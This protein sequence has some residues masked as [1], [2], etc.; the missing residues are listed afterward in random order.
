MPIIWLQWLVKRLY[1]LYDHFLCPSDLI[2][3]PHSTYFELFLWHS[4]A[5]TKE[6]QKLLLFFPVRRKKRWGRWKGILET[7]S[8]MKCF[9]L[10][11]VN[12]VICEGTLH[13]SICNPV[14]M[15]SHSFLVGET[16]NQP[17]L[18]ICKDNP[19]WN[20]KEKTWRV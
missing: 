6:H 11:L 4:T 20:I 5:S 12:L 15:T 17:Y 2:L 1:K 3:K 9:H 13:G 16:I 14:T 8:A 7:T 10:Q 18:S 19:Q